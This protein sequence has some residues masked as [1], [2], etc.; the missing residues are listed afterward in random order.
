MG[1]LLRRWPEAAAERAQARWQ[2]YEDRRSAEARFVRDMNLVD[3]AL[4]AWIYAT[5]ERTPERDAME[6]F[7]ASAEVRVETSFGRAL[8]AD[9]VAAARRADDEEDPRA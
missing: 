7:L 6:E 2:A 5:T 1:A 3:M 8:L 4:Q 9:I